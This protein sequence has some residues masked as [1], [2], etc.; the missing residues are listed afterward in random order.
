MSELELLSPAVDDP[1]EW[2][3]PARRGHSLRLFTIGDEAFENAYGAIESATRR[4]WLETYIFEPDEV[5]NAARDALAAAAARGCDV[6][7][8]FDHLGSPKI[9]HKYSEPIIDAGGRVVAYNPVLPWRKLGRKV[10]PYFHRDH[11]KI[12][13]TDDIGFCGG[14]NVSRDYG[15]PG[16]ELFF[17]MT[18]RIEGP[19]VRDLAA[20]ILDSVRDA[21][22]F[23]PPIP[24]RS[25]P[26]PGGAEVQ[27][28][29]LDHRK[30]QCDLDHALH[31]ALTNASRRCFL[32]TPYF[33]PRSWFIDLLTS[34]SRRGVDVRILTAGKSDVPLA[35]VAGRHMY[36]TL[37]KAGIR[38]YEMDHPILHAKCVTVDG[39]YSMI[40]S[41]NV[42]AYGGKHN[43][44][45]GIGVD[46]EAL[47]KQLED[48]FLEETADA[49]VVHLDEWQHRSLPSRAAE[50]ALYQAFRI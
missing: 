31:D 21:S 24:A 3:F 26:R 49:H 34:V 7:L 41:Y 36:G 25:D 8:L 33:V 16:P 20:V 38:V 39:H 9:G 14:A 47:A 17:D 5:G 2:R 44:E 13:V 27:V 37:L 42:D 43:L 40:G 48:V 18:L 50:W 15:G 19:A 1:F 32:M 23:A 45:V 22:G 30:R 11:R 35:R 10:A 28:L 4:V 29:A 6:I 46:D 12:L